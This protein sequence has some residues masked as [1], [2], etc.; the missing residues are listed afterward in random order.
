MDIKREKIAQLCHDQWSG[1]MKYLFSKCY[2]EKGQFDRD[3]GNLGIPGVFVDRWMRQMNTDYEDLS[4]PEKDSDRK[5]ADKFIDL[6][7]KIS[8]IK[9]NK[10]ERKIVDINN[11]VEG[12]DMPVCPLCDNEVEEID[13]VCIVKS[14]GSLALAH[15]FC[16][17]EFT[18]FDQ[19]DFSGIGLA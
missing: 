8:N 13:E 14:N 18:S 6:L 5:E 1:W 19:P 7:S 2:P 4:E 12:E 15:K 17:E 9:E 3:S 11:E 16:V 10:M